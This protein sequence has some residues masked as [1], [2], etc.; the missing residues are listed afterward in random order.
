M[1][2]E[3]KWLVFYTKSR[4]EKK[5]MEQLERF[6]FEGYLPLQNVV[7][8][9]SDRKKKVQIPLFNSY[10]FV[11]DHESQIGKILQ[12]I[13]TIS[14]NIRHNG[15]P[16]VLR[17]QEMDTI[18]RFLETGLTLETQPIDNLNTGD[19][20]EVMDGP[21]RGSVGI[22]TGDFNEQK[23]SI[24]IETIDQMLTANLPKHILKKLE[25]GS[26]TEGFWN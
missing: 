25:E 9:W 23:F 5:A 12:T 1:S 17:D 3:K 14:W 11:R 8:Q 2:L 13:P 18:R 16:A 7:K 6:G 21:L 4:S 24:V 10:I 19:K 20:V 22:L 26:N 15:K